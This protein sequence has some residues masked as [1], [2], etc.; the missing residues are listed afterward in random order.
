MQVITLCVAWFNVPINN[1]T[2]QIIAFDDSDKFNFSSDKNVV[3]LVLDTF[4]SDL[5]SDIVLGNDSYKNVFDGFIYYP[6]AVGG[7]PTTYPSIPLLLTGKYYNNNVP[8]QDFIKDSYLSSSS[9]PYQLLNNGYD[10]DLYP[11]VNYTVYPSNKVASNW[12]SVK[13]HKT[14][15]I[16]DLE[17]MYKV[18]FFRYMPHVFKRF[19]YENVIND[20]MAE[21]NLND[22]TFVNDLQKKFNVSSNNKMFKFIHLRGAHPP[23]HINSQLEE[24]KL[25]YSYKGYKEQAEAELKIVGI[26]IKKLKEFGVYD[27][28]MMLVLGDHGLGS[29]DVRNKFFGNLENDRV[30][31][32]VS[33]KL[34]SFGIPLILAKPFASS[35]LMKISK[36][37]VSLSDIP[38]TIFKELNMSTNIE[39]ISLFDENTISP[40]ER[41]F[42]MYNWK[43]D[44]WSK[45]YLPPMNEY[46]V[47]GFS[48]LSSSWTPTYRELSNN[49]VKSIAP[50][51][52][53]YNTQISFC[54][55]GNSGY[56]KGAGWSEPE[57][58]FTWTD[59]KNASLI[60]P[61]E[62]HNKDLILRAS[63]IP[64]TIDKID[65]QKVD[66]YVNGE[67]V[68]QWNVCKPGQYDIV[69][70][71]E[72]VTGSQLKIVF[73]VSDPASPF[74]QG[75]SNDK[76]DLGIAFKS[77]E[78]STK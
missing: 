7:F 40:R 36:A 35:G 72:Y 18:S 14:N 63:L 19:Y 27:N 28:T 8:I 33:S 49:G 61:I 70:P 34:V 4:Q 44:D 48:W 74:S 29:F 16:K 12:I 13:G 45:E 15:K 55:G 22:L 69:L 71:K 75:I 57:E 60:I 47:S 3:I 41:K 24:E 59:G 58:S 77:I 62:N 21:D 56:Y 23:F 46:T 2:N 37:P 10:V 11:Q 42:Y 67:S 76:R 1:D 26:L 50:P 43:N 31:K 64:F 68:G 25:E 5:F 17:I 30:V 38:I 39:G 9:I 73:R 53:K 78:I 52:Y 6:N 66:I 32:P 54:V 20:L 65:K 51:L